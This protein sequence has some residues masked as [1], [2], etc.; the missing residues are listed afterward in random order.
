VG[1]VGIAATLPML[2]QPFLALMERAMDVF[3]KR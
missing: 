3:A 2:D 1:L